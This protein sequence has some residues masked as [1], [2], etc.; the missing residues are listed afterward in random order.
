MV[1]DVNKVFRFNDFKDAKGGTELM[2]SQ[3]LK[4]VDND[5]LSKFDI[6]V[7]YPPQDFVRGEKPVI[8]WL[9]DLYSDPYF[10][11]LKNPR[12]QNNFD[13]FMFVS[14]TQ[15]EL[16]RIKFGLPHSKC[17]VGEN[18]IEPASTFKNIKWSKVD[19][20]KILYSSSP[21]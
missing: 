19:K 7:S 4:Y 18:A 1:H 3:L 5:L 11:I 6:I 15:K 8:L 10:D 21:I 9:H 17:I 16:F 12:Y 13:Y 2:V 14:Y 20:V